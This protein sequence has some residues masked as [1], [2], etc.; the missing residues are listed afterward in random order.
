VGKLKV[1][2][3]MARNSP[4]F[5]FLACVLHKKWCQTK[6]LQRIISI[7]SAIWTARGYSFAPLSRFVIVFVCVVHKI[8]AK[9]KFTFQIK[10]ALLRAINFPRETGHAELTFSCSK[11]F[12]FKNTSALLRIP[13]LQSTT[14]IFA[15]HLQ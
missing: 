15:L 9:C 3:I 4:R 5:L 12:C 11:I 7:W 6:K 2:T 13:P 8:G 14:N 1:Y 10:H